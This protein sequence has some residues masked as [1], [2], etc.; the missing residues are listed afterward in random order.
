M[1]ETRFHRQL[2]LVRPEALNMPITV[3]GA[4]GIGSFAAWL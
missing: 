1:D 3:V 2:D 4:G